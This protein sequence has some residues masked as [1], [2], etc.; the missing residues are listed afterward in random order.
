MFKRL[1]NLR[2]KGLSVKEYTGEF[3]ELNIRAGH[4]END[5]KK[6]VRY[7]NGWR[8]KIQDEI[9]LV[10]MMIVEYDYQVALK[11]KEN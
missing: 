7:I 10:T 8:Y 9:S 2:Q 1:Q 3:Y 6:V 5:E 4:K 11:T